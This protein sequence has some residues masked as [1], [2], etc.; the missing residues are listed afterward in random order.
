MIWDSVGDGADDPGGA[1]SQLRVLSNM[2]TL[3]ARVHPAGREGRRLSAPTSPWAAVGI[4]H[5][6]GPAGRAR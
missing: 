2:V 6:G 1:A 4:R 3:Y 5:L